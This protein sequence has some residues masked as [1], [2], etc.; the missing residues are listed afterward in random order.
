M[1][2]EL[3]DYP[4][5]SQRATEGKRGVWRRLSP[6]IAD[7]DWI[8]T[9]CMLIAVMLAAAAL[10]GP[11]A[12]HYD[13]D[14]QKL[15]NRLRPPLFFGGDSSHVLGTD[16]LGRD[17]LTRCFYG[18]RLSLGLS[19]LG[20]VLGLALGGL[21]G[22]TAGLSGN[23]VDDLIMGFVDLQIAVPFTLIALLAV[24]VFGNGLSVLVVVLGVAYWEH[25]CRL[26]RGQVVAIRS[27]LYIDAARV[28]GAS[29][30]RLAWRHVA[31]NIL[32]PLIVMF[33]INISNLL[34]LESSLSFLGLGVQPPTATLG[35]MVGQGRDYM[36]TAPWIVLGPAL[37]IVLVALVVMM[38]G[39]WLRDRLDV[40]LQDRK[41]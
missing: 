12:S 1:S 15:L 14:S 27:Q 30:W 4:L 9:G 5:V 11:L 36:A 23:L 41:A 26:M 32:S 37:L 19:L 7:T 16:Q 22:V 34:L 6:A 24:A 21:L 40:R 13:P 29:A 31:P 25:Y 38:L 10:L 17:I 39:D 33:T 18:L 8:M 3:L 35:A 28:A 2:E 20:S